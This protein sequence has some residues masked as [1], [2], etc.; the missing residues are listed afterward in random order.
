MAQPL[1]VKQANALPPSRPDLTPDLFS[2]PSVTDAEPGSTVTSDLVTLS[3]FDGEITVTATGG[4]TVTPSSVSRGQSLVMT[5][6]TSSEFGA[7][8]SVIVTAGGVSSAWTVTTRV[9]D[10]APNAFAI[11]ARMG[12]AAG[13]TVTSAAI[14]PTSYDAPISVGATNGATTSQS[15]ISPGKPFTATMLALSALRTSKTTAI[16]VGTTSARWNVTVRSQDVAPTPST[17]RCARTPP[18]RPIWRS[19][20]GFRARL[21]PH[22]EGLPVFARSPAEGEKRERIFRSSHRFHETLA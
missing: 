14:T 6:D 7:P 12:V 10:M 15:S 21:R 20:T 19:Q 2:I 13:E 8:T 17:S 5:V 9:Q 4:A 3:S 22:H 11:P 1:S 18:P 16:S